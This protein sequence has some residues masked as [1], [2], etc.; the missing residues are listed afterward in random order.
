[1]IIVVNIIE[2][3]A[4]FQIFT[5]SVTWLHKYFS[6]QAHANYFVHFY[7]HIDATSQELHLKLKYSAAIYQILS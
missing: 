2:F 4:N 1:M 6:F 5:Q 3:I 7:Y